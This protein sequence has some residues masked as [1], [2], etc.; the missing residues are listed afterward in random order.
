MRTSLLVLAPLCAAT[1]L[2]SAC[3]R[4]AETETNA[5]EPAAEVAVEPAPVEIDEG[6]DEAILTE[7]PAP[8]SDNRIPEPFHGTWDES[9]ESCRQ[10]SDARLVIGPD[11]LRYHESLGK[12]ELVQVRPDNEIVLRLA[13]SGEGDHW[14]A[15]ERLALAADGSELYDRGQQ[16]AFVRVRC[17]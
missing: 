6:I 9:A 11:E 4:D 1:L 14:T 3:N 16:P 10:A 17:R 8:G 5:V 15:T 7:A 12:V 13:V 2:L